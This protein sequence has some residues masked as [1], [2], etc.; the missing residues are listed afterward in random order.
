MVH[1]SANQIALFES[2]EGGGGNFNLKYFYDIDSTLCNLIAAKN[3][4]SKIYLV[5]SELS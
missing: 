2:S 1:V 3:A 4:L 5:I